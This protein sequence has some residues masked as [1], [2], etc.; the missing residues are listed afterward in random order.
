MTEHEEYINIL[1]IL[2]FMILWICERLLSR[3]MTGCCVYMSFMNVY[4]VYCIWIAQLFS[5]L[6]CF[7][8]TLKKS[9]REFCNLKN[10]LKIFYAQLWQEK[11]PMST[12]HPFSFL[13]PFIFLFFSERL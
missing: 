3:F 1:K 10:F 2:E 13:E 6:R 7:D 9:K 12:R 8:N 11:A 4:L 5:I